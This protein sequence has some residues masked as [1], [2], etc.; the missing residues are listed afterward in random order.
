MDNIK[1]ILINVN[2]IHA[3]L[4]CTKGALAKAV[5]AA[6]QMVSTQALEREDVMAAPAANILEVVGVNV[7]AVS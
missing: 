1:V 3:R 7:H 6:A 2:A 5:A 4:E